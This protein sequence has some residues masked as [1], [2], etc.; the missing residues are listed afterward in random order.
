MSGPGPGKRGRPVLALRCDERPGTLPPAGVR[1]RPFAVV[2]G[3][4]GPA[5][6]VAMTGP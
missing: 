6:A 2:P 1:R 4:V 5:P 3:M